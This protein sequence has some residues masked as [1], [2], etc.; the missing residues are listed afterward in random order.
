METFIVE[1]H[2]QV[3]DQLEKILPM[4]AEPAKR[5]N[6]AIRYSVFSGGK[7]I[8]P[9]LCYGGAC[10]VDQPDENTTKIAASLEMMHTYSL[11]HDDLPAMDDDSLR[12]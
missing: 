7:R 11:I 2:D 3:N 1:C 5:L 12:S 9:L 6:T 8:R 10:A 4:E